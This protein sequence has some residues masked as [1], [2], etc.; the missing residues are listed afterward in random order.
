MSENLT[1]EG[2]IEKAWI[3]QIHV[4]EDGCF[5]DCPSFCDDCVWLSYWDT[6]KTP[7]IR[8]V[9]KLSETFQ[10]RSYQGKAYTYFSPTPEAIQFLINNCVVEIEEE[11]QRLIAAAITRQEARVIYEK[12]K[13]YIE[14][15]AAKAAADYYTAAR[16]EKL[17]FYIDGGVMSHAI[18]E[19]IG[20]GRPVVALKCPGMDSLNSHFWLSGW[21]HENEHHEIVVDETGEIISFEEAIIRCCQE[22]D[23]SDLIESMLN[24]IEDV[25]EEEKI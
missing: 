25:V 7:L 20:K 6:R 11:K 23:I 22:W 4:D 9:K 13:E 2:V 15:N 5:S 1:P 16:G 8:E 18:G 24:Q 19:V 21:A 17:G 3:R 10:V 12:I 14:D